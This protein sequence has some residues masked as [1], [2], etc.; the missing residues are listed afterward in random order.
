MNE[1][2]LLARETFHLNGGYTRVIW[3]RSENTTGAGTGWIFDIP[4]HVI[5]DDLRVIDSCFL[6]QLIER[7]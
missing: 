7:I 2:L 5:P 1:R 6:L 3:K 4:T